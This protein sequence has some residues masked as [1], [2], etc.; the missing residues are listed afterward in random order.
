MHDRKRILTVPNALSA[1]RI[2][3]GPV[4]LCMIVY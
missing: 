4:I 3:A 2:A 1:Y